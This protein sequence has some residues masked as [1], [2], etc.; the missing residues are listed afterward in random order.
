MRPNTAATWQLLRNTVNFL[1]Y[2]TGKNTVG[3]EW[4]S[5]MKWKKVL[6]RI[7]EDVQTEQNSSVEG[8]VHVIPAHCSIWQI[9]NLNARKINA[10]N[11][12]RGKENNSTCKSRLGLW[13]PAY[14]YLEMKTPAER[15]ELSRNNRYFRVIDAY[16]L[17]KWLF[18]MENIFGFVDCALQ[19]Q[20]KS[21]CL[22]QQVYWSGEAVLDIWPT[23]VATLHALFLLFSCY[24]TI[25]WPFAR[26]LT[27]RLVPLLL[28]KCCSSWSSFSWCSLLACLHGRAGSLQTRAISQ[29]S[30]CCL[31]MV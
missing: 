29:T 6:K 18:H 20:L 24:S 19:I 22:L 13:I 30:L 21:G 9:A 31:F 1:K 15:K 17:C 23:S 2:R 3:F 8:N 12:F 27:A 7:K 10:E 25:N 5:H 14:V 11:C 4:A 16:F 26:L 28:C